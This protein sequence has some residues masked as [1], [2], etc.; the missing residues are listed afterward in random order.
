[1][2]TTLFATKYKGDF[3]NGRFV[4]VEK[5]DGEFKDISPSDLNDTVMVVPFKHD[6][7]DEACVAAKKAYPSWACLSLTE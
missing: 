5:G 2:S 6:H 4:P 7:I 1:M 3:I